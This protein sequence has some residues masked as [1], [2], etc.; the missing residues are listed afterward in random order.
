MLLILF[1][2]Q[3]IHAETQHMSE[4]KSGRANPDEE[5][6]KFQ[7]LLLQTYPSDPKNKYYIYISLHY[8]AQTLRDFGKNIC[9]Q[10]IQVTKSCDLDEEFQ[11]LLESVQPDITE[12]QTHSVFTNEESME[13]N[14]KSLGNSSSTPIFIYKITS[15]YNSKCISKKD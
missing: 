11:I 12:I 1:T 3:D 5:E 6:G 10:C 4:P 13:V 9:F 14:E 2:L 15:P 7:C 8:F